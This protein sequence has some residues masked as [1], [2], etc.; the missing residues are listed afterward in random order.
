MRRLL[1]F[2]LVLAVVALGV[3]FGAR[4]FAARQIGDAVQVRLGL[5][6]R[7]EVTIAGFPFL[8]QAVRGEYRSI[9]ARLPATTLGPLTGVS[10]GVVLDGV[11]LPLSDAL[12]GDV[13]RL[14]AD[15]GRARLTVPAASIG[16]AAGLPGL[17]VTTQD[18]GLLLAATVTVL[19]Q[20]VPVTARL[21]ATVTD[22]VLTLR[23]GGIE[24]AG[25]ALPDGAGAALGDLGNL[26]DLT[27][28]LD[29]L[30]FAVTSGTVQAAGSNLIVDASTSALDFATG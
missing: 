16:T 21:D 2:L 23:S 25:I 9:G 19:G 24:A 18:G 22:G 12:G 14:T 7:P 10:A 5:D 3:D 13:D 27:V 20:Q 26:V 11:R 15:S 28:P 8:V 29:G 1:G 30:P 4:L 17:A 6:E